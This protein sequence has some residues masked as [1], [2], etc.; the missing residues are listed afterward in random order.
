M[1][2]LQSSYKILLFDKI[3]PSGKCRQYNGCL[4]IV[5][6]ILHESPFSLLI[7]ISEVFFGDKDIKIRHSVFQTITA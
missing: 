3:L 5:F 6:H 7:I 4:S 1:A 2:D